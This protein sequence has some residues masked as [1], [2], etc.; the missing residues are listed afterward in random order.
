VATLATAHQA[1]RLRLPMPT[2][3]L[4]ST[5]LNADPEGRPVELGTTWF[6][7]DRVAL[8]LADSEASGA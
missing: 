7:G 3:L 5:H 8:V 4:R 2:A 1:A 6:A